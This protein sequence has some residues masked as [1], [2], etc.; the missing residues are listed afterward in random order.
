MNALVGI[1]NREVA[2][3]AVFIA[4]V[5]QEL[6]V[7]DA[8]DKYR[9]WGS[10]SAGVAIL[11][12]VCGGVLISFGLVSVAAV[13]FVVAVD[14]II[15]TLF[16]AGMLVEGQGDNALRLL[17]AAGALMTVISVPFFL[18]GPRMA[19]F[20]LAFS[21]MG[22]IGG[23]LAYIFSNIETPAADGGSGGGG[24]GGHIS[25]SRI[26]TADPAA[27]LDPVLRGRMNCVDDR[28]PYGTGSTYAP[29]YRGKVLEATREAFKEKGKTAEELAA[30]RLAHALAY[31]VEEGSRPTRDALRWELRVQRC[32]GDT[33]VAAPFIVV[34]P[35]SHTIPGTE[36][37]LPRG[38]LAA[39]DRF[40]FE[41]FGQHFAHTGILLPHGLTATEIRRAVVDLH[42]AQSV[43]W[44]E[45]GPL[46]FFTALLGQARRRIAERGPAP[47]SVWAPT[48]TD[49]RV[50]GSGL[51]TALQQRSG[52]AASTPAGAAVINPLSSQPP[53]ASNYDF[54]GGNKDVDHGPQYGAP[55]VAH[56]S[57]GGWGATTV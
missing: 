57:A 50:N 8:D 23:L 42:G 46:P 22:W 10:R 40:P 3:G 11:G 13:A 34:A 14:A 55:R 21:G 29:E 20:A 19:G 2:E 30:Y 36:H 25:S 38:T 31:V 16:C 44:S 6:T 7:S 49:T 52:A 17:V 56:D 43:G 9:V 5:Q 47:S 54:W 39:A 33:R 45:Q 1:L 32:A 37:H 26:T 53:P 18:T 28:G 41:S 51:G 27:C 24:G 12:I 4:A 35:L 15:S 48:L